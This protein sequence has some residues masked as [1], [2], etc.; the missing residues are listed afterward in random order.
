MVKCGSFTMQ[1]SSFSV[2]G[3]GFKPRWLILLYSNGSTENSWTS[4]PSAGIGWAAMQ[5]STVD[6]SGSSLRTCCVHEIWYNAGNVAA[7]G[8]LGDATMWVRATNGSDGWAAYISS[9]NTDG[10]T[11]TLIGG[12]TSGA[13]GQRIY[14]L[15]GDDA[16][17]EVGSTSAFATGVGA[18]NLGWQPQAFFGIGAGGG[19]GDAPRYSASFTDTSVPSVCSGDW[20]EYTDAALSMNAQ[21]RGILDPNVNVQEWWGRDIDSNLITI[22]EAQQSGGAWFSDWFSATRTDTSFLGTISDTGFSNGDARM[23]PFILGSVD[24]IVGSFTP[25]LTVGVPTQVDLPFTPEAVVFFSPQFNKSGVGNTSTHGATGW[26]FC[27]ETDQA[28][29]IYGG[30]WNPP[31]A[32]NSSMLL[33]S[34]KCWV[35]NCVESSTVGT[36]VNAGSAQINDA[37]FEYETT[38]NAASVAYPIL[39]WAFAPAE[40]APGFFR[41]IA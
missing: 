23:Q 32:M 10:F 1:A 36:I 40:E 4:G 2:T 14:Y 29:L 33:S 8:F 31:T 7:G 38:E 12:F 39:Y 41:I 20:G 25:S 5:N 30:F 13:G 34:N 11:V 15:A 37:G 18:Y 19:L 17:E 21:W 24:S 28:L 26:G 22:L 3:L 27:T 16:Y 35:G 6:D 9:L